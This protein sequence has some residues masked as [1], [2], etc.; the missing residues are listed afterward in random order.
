MSAAVF[1]V[2]CGLLPFYLAVVVVIIA[3]KY[4]R[5]GVRS[6]FA[7]PERIELKSRPSSEMR[8]IH[9]KLRAH[10]LQKSYACSGRT[11]LFALALILASTL[12]SC[13]AVYSLVPSRSPSSSRHV[14][15]AMD[16]PP[17]S[18]HIVVD[19]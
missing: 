1:Y 6:V 14:S 4:G 15:P 3:R 5:T 9:I 7:Q 13:I 17:S 8:L 12:L 2:L 18:L 19:A 10:F 11:V 16:L